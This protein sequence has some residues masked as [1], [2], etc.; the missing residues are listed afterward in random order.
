MLFSIITTDFKKLGVVGGLGPA[1]SVRFYEMLVDFTAAE[2]DCDHIDAIIYSRASVPDRT[3]YLLGESQKSPVL[4]IIETIH[5]LESL[6]ADYIAI[7]CITAHSFYGELQSA[8]KVPVINMVE[9][10]AKSL[11]KAGIKRAGIMATS[12]TS[13]S[14]IMQKALEAYEIEAVLPDPDGQDVIM[15]II[16]DIKAAKVIEH[17]VFKAQSDK[18]LEA[19]A[20]NI[21]LSCTELSLLKRYFDLDS[22]HTDAMEVL[23][24]RSIELCGAKLKEVL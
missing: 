22:T 17:S 4:P 20:E 14:G 5:M 6:N 15:Q 19:G 18:L 12:G 21:V 16:N 10:T 11:S 13:K 24:K 9:E 2:R 8:A 1:A 3:A 23:A 7:P